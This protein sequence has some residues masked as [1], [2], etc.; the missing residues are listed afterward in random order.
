MVFSSKN[1]LAINQDQTINSLTNDLSNFQQRAFQYFGPW[2]ETLKTMHLADSAKKKAALWQDVESLFLASSQEHP[3]FLLTE[4]GT[5]DRTKKCPQEC[6]LE[7][8][9]NFKEGARAAFLTRLLEASEKVGQSEI[10]A[11][12]FYA[13]GGALFEMQI[14][15]SLF[16]TGRAFSNI[17]LIDPDYSFSAEDAQEMT[18]PLAERKAIQ[19]N[20]LRRLYRHIQLCNFVWSLNP[21]AKIFV[22][23]NSS[24]YLSDISAQQAPTGNMLVSMDPISGTYLLS[25]GAFPQANVMIAELNS[26]KQSLN[27]NAVVA[28]NYR[29]SGLSQEVHFVLEIK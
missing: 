25:N 17:I 29:L 18:K 28:I 22:Y 21:S 6:P 2:L 19:V 16:P 4:C 20:S 12:V 10:D 15:A 23:R 27:A 14:L 26:L 9:E 24:A 13:S 1:A 11:V 8:L 7:R 5:R 3:L